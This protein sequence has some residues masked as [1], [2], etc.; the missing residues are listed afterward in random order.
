MHRLRSVM[1]YMEPQKHEAFS[2]LLAWLDAEDAQLLDVAETRTIHARYTRFFRFWI[3]RRNGSVLVK[4][5]FDLLNRP[6]TVCTGWDVFIAPR[7]GHM[8]RGVI[9][10]AKELLG[11]PI[12]SPRTVP[13]LH[14]IMAQVMSIMH[15]GT[16]LDATA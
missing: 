15:P 5:D 2:V 7:E 6:R 9:D 11:P 1:D 3:S 12:V 10:N 13:E 8:D 16:F 14:P 4:A